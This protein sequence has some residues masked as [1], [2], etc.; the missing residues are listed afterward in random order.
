MLRQSQDPHT[1]CTCPVES[2]DSNCDG[3]IPITVFTWLNCLLKG[4][5]YLGRTNLTTRAFIFKSRS[6]RQSKKCEAWEGL[7]VS[8][9]SLQ[10][11]LRTSHLIGP[12]RNLS[13]LRVRLLV[14]PNEKRKA[15]TG[16]CPQGSKLCQQSEGFQGP[17]KESLANVLNF[18]ALWKLKWKTQPHIAGLWDIKWVRF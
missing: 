14:G 2:R 11:P 5:D 10:P 12:E 7:Y 6:H 3:L 17:P 15:G 1:K 9:D 16:F 4:E 13:E 18:L 8:G